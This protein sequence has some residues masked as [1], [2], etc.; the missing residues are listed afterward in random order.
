MIDLRIRGMP[1]RSASFLSW[2]ISRDTI[3]FRDIR[4]VP[5]SADFG[6]KLANEALDFHG[7]VGAREFRL[8]LHVQH[9]VL[10]LFQVF[11]C[12]HQVGFGG[13]VVCQRGEHDVFEGDLARQ[14]VDAG[15]AIAP[16]IV[17]EVGLACGGERLQLLPQRDV[18]TGRSMSFTL[19]RAPKAEDAV[20]KTARL[21]RHWTAQWC[22]LT[23]MGPG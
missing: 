11:P 10:R 21:I 7:A 6:F 4:G 19:L 1:S 9:F 15:F 14:F 5:G 3:F 20:L 12:L 18:I 2:S 8:G 16:G 17:A 23:G 13:I 22:T